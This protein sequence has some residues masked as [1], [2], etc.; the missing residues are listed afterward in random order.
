MDCHARSLTG[1]REILYLNGFYPQPH[2]ELSGCSSRGS[3]AMLRTIQHGVPGKRERKEEQQQQLDYAKQHSQ[4]RLF[5]LSPAGRPTPWNGTLP[6]W[7][8]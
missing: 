5:D 4:I 1:K 6:Y 7:I 3:L 8:H 2:A